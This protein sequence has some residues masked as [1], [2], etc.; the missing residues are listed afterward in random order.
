MLKQKTKNPDVIVPILLDSAE[1]CKEKAQF[2][3][4]QNLP[5]TILNNYNMCL[6]TFF[7]IYKNIPIFMVS[8]FN[9][10]MV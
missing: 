6:N 5:H 7:Y 2:P 10:I 8:S 3:H 1:K 4:H 9:I